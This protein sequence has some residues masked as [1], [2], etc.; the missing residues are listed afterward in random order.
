MGVGTIIHLSTVDSR[1]NEPRREM[2]NSSLYREFVNSEI[3]K[4]REFLLK[5]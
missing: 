4:N 2:N 1:C 3:E 5:Y